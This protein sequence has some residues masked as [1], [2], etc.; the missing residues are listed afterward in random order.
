M[1]FTLPKWDHWTA[2]GK[3]FMIGVF[4]VRYLGDRN[5]DVN[6]VA[7]QIGERRYAL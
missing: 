1:I 3:I 5:A 4:R 6:A 2:G 7:K